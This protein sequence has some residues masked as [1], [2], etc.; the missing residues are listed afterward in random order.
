MSTSLRRHRALVYSYT[1]GGTDG[2]IGDQL[3]HRTLQR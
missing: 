2:G 1:D 3:R